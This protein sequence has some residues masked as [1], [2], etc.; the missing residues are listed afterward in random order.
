MDRPCVILSHQITIF[1][2]KERQIN[3]MTERERNT[4]T[5][6]VTFAMIVYEQFSTIYTFDINNMPAFVSIVWKSEKKT[7]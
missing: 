7:I 5:L 2:S 4:P 1:I 3:G 6:N